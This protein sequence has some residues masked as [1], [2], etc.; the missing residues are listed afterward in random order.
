[1]P[2]KHIP[3][4]Q[5]LDPEGD[6]AQEHDS[7]EW[8]ERQ[9]GIKEVSRGAWEMQE[10]GLTEQLVVVGKGGQGFHYAIYTSYQ[11][12]DD[13]AWNQGPPW[14]EQAFLTQDA[15]SEAAHELMREAGRGSESPYKEESPY[16]PEEPHW[17]QAR[18]IEKRE[19]DETSTRPRNEALEKHGPAIEGEI[20]EQLWPQA[21]D[22]EPGTHG[23]ARDPDIDID[24]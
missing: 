4:E 7:R 24:R 1:M 12:S 23:P 3:G 21:R 22:D 14:S 19:W 15:A 8:Q 13:F 10:D 16:E 20:L 18:D 9:S 5:S 2:D 6:A 11:G 17:P